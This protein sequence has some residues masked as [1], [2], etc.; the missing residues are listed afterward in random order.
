MGQYKNMKK[1]RLHC[2]NKLLNK[3]SNY[4]KV[5]D[6]PVVT[7]EF[8]KKSYFDTLTME[9]VRNNFKFRSKMTDVKFNYRSKKE[10]SSV[11]WKCSSCMSAIE[12]QVHILWCPSYSSLREGKSLDNDYIKKV[13]T[14]R[15]EIAF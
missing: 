3:I 10:N 15:E 14:I 6:G 5:K 8:N 7:E 11:L 12:T 1:V 2:K 9:G 4:S 13:L